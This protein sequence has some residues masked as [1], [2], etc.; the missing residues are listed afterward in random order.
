MIDD[1]GS[2]VRHAWQL[3]SKSSAIVVLNARGEVQ[4]VKEGAL[5]LEEVRQVVT[6]IQRLMREQER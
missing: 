3:K 5:T 4:W 6:L 1:A 2:V